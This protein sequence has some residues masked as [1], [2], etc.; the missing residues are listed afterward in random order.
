MELKRYWR[1]IWR[2]MW[3]ILTLTLV[4]AVASAFSVMLRPA[5]NGSHVASLRIALSLPPDPR[6]GDS[7][8]FDSRV[9]AFIATEYLVDDFAEVIKSRAF[10][11][12]IRRELGDPNADIAAI[13]ATK[14]TE[15][16]HRI[17]NI[18]ITSG[19]K[20]QALRIAEAAVKVI[21]TKA[22]KYFSQLGTDQATV[23]VIDPP[24]L[25]AGTT[26]S[27]NYQLDIALR[28]ALGL[29]AGLGL[30]LV[31]HYLDST[32]YDAE[33]VE[34][35]LSLPILGQIPPEG[36]GRSRLLGGVSP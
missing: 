17:L 36:R 15:K 26:L 21:E 3:I 14:K 24:S 25:S 11:E 22:N 33:E 19:D 34:E 27:R 7:P 1:I 6:A 18:E 23:K 4:V 10:A 2:R 28:T 20:G 31:L 35:L 12:D 13:Q 5:S 16:T 32:I 30:V 9:Q 29:M 8:I